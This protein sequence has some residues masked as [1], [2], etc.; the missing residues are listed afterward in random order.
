MTNDLTP[1]LSFQYTN[2]LQ[3]DDSGKIN[4]LSIMSTTTLEAEPVETTITT[5]STPRLQGKLRDIGL[6]LLL[7]VGALLVAGYHPWAE[8]AEIYLPGVEKALHPELF[9]FDAQ[10]FLAHGHST[11]FPNVIA[12][13]VRLNHLSLEQA[14]FAWQ[15]ISIFV[16]LLACLELSRRCFD[17]PRAW[18]SGVTLMA[19]LLTLPVAGTALYIL[20][21]YPNPRNLAAF[22]SIF[23]IAKALDKKYAQMGLLLILTAVV[24][25]LM[26][27][28]A[29]LYC[30]LLPV[31]TGSPSRIASFAAIVPF[32]L[33]FDPAAPA[34]HLAALRE[35]F[36]YI[37]H[38]HWY[39]LVGALAPL[40]ILWGFSR[41]AQ[42]RRMRN[43]EL[44]CRALIVY[45]LICLP[46]ALLLSVIPRFESLARLQPMRCLFLLYIM[47]FLFGGCLLGEYLLKDRAWR[48]LALF[49][50][51]CVG[52][53]LAQRALFPKDAHIEWP[54]TRSN[55]DWV[56]AFQWIRDNTPNNA[57]F[58]L[59]AEY[60]Q[61]PGEDE[62][63]FRA[64]A[65]RSMLAD[66]RDG[67][68]VSMFPA[69]ADAWLGQFQ[70]RSNWS[71]FEKQ[72]F[73]K[74]SDQYGVTWFV[75]E[76]QAPAGLDCPYRN[77][78]VEVCRL[79]PSITP[80]GGNGTPQSGF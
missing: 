14:L 22:L 8:D 49:V 18:W 24:H 64:I 75:I 55:N 25:P 50:P 70:S 67:G 6:L 60:M 38:W 39:E 34:Y 41:L 71:S 36:H 47:M 42:N 1:A 40:L 37:T 54:G 16:F 21:Q 5:V 17:N 46:P 51:L 43:L 76:R 62:Q 9:P 33:S 48:W 30:A 72:D 78:A 20:D 69:L 66:S 52:M 73:Q 3:P 29:I 28:F 77:S 74:L 31:I 58:A 23:A 68:A 13:S 2:P 7:T 63:G 44:S 19:A 11:I 80:S 79:G 56:Q 35:P 10:F 45:E 59:N 32:G 53:F 65:Q 12:Y 4:S 61:L 57:Y 15:I 26:S 27:A